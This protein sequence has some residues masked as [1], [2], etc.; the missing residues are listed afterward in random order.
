MVPIIIKKVY[1]SKMRQYNFKEFNFTIY[2]N[3]KYNKINKLRIYNKINTLKENAEILGIYVSN[4][5][6]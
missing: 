4:M 2:Y 1:I 5:R 6:I 3:C